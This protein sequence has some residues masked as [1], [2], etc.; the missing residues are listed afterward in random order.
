M[1]KDC[2]VLVLWYF[3]C[4]KFAL[5]IFISCCSLARLL[6]VFYCWHFFSSLQMY[7]FFFPSL[8]FHLITRDDMRFHILLLFSL[9]VSRCIAST[10]PTNPKL[11]SHVICCKKM[12]IRI[13]SS[14]RKNA[15]N[16]SGKE[17]E[18]Q[19]HAYSKYHMSEFFFLLFSPFV[20]HVCRA[21]VRKEQQY[22]NAC[23]RIVILN[24][25]LFIPFISQSFV[26]RH[27]YMIALWLKTSL[28]AQSSSYMHLV[29]QTLSAADGTAI[30]SIFLWQNSK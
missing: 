8:Q 7:T 10:Y 16:N 21:H 12:K 26:N 18:W 30:I 23:D 27:H 25:C 28:N 22:I 15:H 3:D 9:C 1:I 17:N 24:G 29:Y 4:L 11:S 6:W 14:L 2:T 20:P 19:N 5:I 13:Y